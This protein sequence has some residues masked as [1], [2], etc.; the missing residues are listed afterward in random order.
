MQWDWEVVLGRPEIA[1]DRDRVVAAV[2]NKCVLITGAGGSIGS[3]VALDCIGGRP[4]ALLLL[5]SSEHSL[6]EIWKRISAQTT[7]GFSQIVPIVGN[8]SDRPLLDLLFRQY[9][10]D[11]I[12]HAAA[13]KHV[14]LMEQ[15]PFRAVA[16]NAVGTFKLV[17]AALENGPCELLLVSTDKAVNP[18]SIMGASKRA[19]ELIILSHSCSAVR[20]NAI[21]LGN[22]LGSSGSVVPLFQE[23]LE[24]GRP[25]TVTHPDARRYFLTSSEAGSAVLCAANCFLSGRILLADCGVPLNILELARY[26][27][28]LYNIN[29][30]LDR[31]TRPEIEFIGLRPGEKLEE[32]LFSTEE[33][34]EESLVSGVR[35]FKSPCPPACD[36]ADGMERI[37]A[38]IRNLD[39]REM[40]AATTHLIGDYRPAYGLRSDSVPVVAK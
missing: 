35:V 22:V 19:A 38:A 20:M 30:G 37:E 40:L 24:G 28:D 23:Q 39:L 1:P 34:M 3:R 17:L 15:N 10:P 18:T 7:N 33:Q 31:R 9:H 2:Q 36:V 25:L 11:L 13:Y 14:P 32:S 4:K 12:F 26:M 16:N 6:Y 29:E 27:A 21:R 5:D 8:F